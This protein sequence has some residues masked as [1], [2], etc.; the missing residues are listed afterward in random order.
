MLFRSDG[1]EEG[2]HAERD[3][4]IGNGSGQVRLS[5]AIVSHQQ[6]PAIQAAGKL[7]GKVK[8]ET[9]RFGLLIGQAKPPAF[10]KGS[11]GHVA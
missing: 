11:K 4:L 3:D 6:Q 5:A 2:W 1:E 10:V 7:L 9:Q 8:G